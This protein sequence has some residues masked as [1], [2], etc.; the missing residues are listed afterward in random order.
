MPPAL[1][2]T[3]FFFVV[4]VLDPRLL[5]A[6]LAQSVCYP[7][8]LKCNITVYGRLPWSQFLLVFFGPNSYVV[9]CGALQISVLW[10]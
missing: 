1:I 10:Q 9:C 7:C 8:I 4:F 2:L 5:A 3:W 6:R